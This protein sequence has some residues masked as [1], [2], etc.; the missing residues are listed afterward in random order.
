MS[1]SP[2]LRLRA[3]VAVRDQNRLLL[4]C[5]QKQGRCY[6]LLPG[7]GVDFGEGAKEAAA[8]EVWEETGLEVEVGRLLLA[9]ETLAP[10]KSRHLVHLVF[11]G[12][13]KSGQLKC[14]DDPRLCDARFVTLA[15]V[16]DL[17]LHPPMTEPLLAVLEERFDG[18]RFLGNLWV[19]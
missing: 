3:A 6:W 19:D 10:D 13:V 11:D 14:G 5:H 12:R 2:A 18:D 16:P 9:S 8:R 1:S 4:V 17:V 15:E 7:G